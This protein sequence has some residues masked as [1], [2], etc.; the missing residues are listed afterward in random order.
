M[1]AHLISLHWCKHLWERQHGNEGPAPVLYCSMSMFYV[2]KK[3]TMKE[4]KKMNRR[5]KYR[6]HYAETLGKAPRY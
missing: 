2:L 6:A 5:P 4:E 1:Q 3:K